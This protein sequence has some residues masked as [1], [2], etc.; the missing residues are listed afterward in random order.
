MRLEAL[1]EVFAGNLL[2]VLA[3]VACGS[4]P[5]TYRHVDTPTATVNEYGAPKNTEYE[6]EFEPAKDQLGITIYEHSV[7]DKIQV[8]VVNRTRETLEGDRVINE[9]PLGKVQVAQQVSGQVPCEQRFAREAQVSLKVGEAVYPV[10]KTDAH[11]HIGVNLAKRL[12]ADVY[13]APEGEMVVLVR[14]QGSVQQQEVGRVP[15]GELRAREQRIEELTGNLSQLLAKPPESMTPEELT[16]AYQLY[17]QLRSV[18]WYDGRFQ[19]LQLRFW[20]VWETQR[21]MR[22][23]QNLSRNVKALDEAKELLR[24]AGAVSIPL[25]AQIGISNGLV[26]ERTSEWARWQMLEGFRG[27]PAACAKGFSWAGMPDYLSVEQQIAGGYLRFVYGD[28]FAQVLSDMCR[29][30]GQL[31]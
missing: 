11:G 9:T 5:V 1:S 23:T 18:A 14:G 31:R 10:G 16:R 6:L 2:A 25:F 15:M 7:C 24:T 20:E 19:G 28:P 12:D 29:Q 22:A 13:G 8:Q 30:V 27:R 26:D 17:A 3:L 4:G 21:S